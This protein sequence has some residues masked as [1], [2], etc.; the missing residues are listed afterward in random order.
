M[1]RRTGPEAEDRSQSAP[2]ATAVGLP[3]PGPCPPGPGDPASKRGTPAPQ[4]PRRTHISPLVLAAARTAP[5]GG[6]LLERRSGLGRRGT[7][8]LGAPGPGRIF[9][10]RPWRGEFS[11][12]SPFR[13]LFHGKVE[14]VGLAGAGATWAARRE[15]R[16]RLTRFSLATRDGTHDGEREARLSV[17][18]LPL[19][20]RVGSL[21]ATRRPVRRLR[22]GRRRGC[23]AVRV[24]RGGGGPDAPGAA[25]WTSPA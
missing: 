16:P 2:P 4:A 8:R 21:R 5:F 6:W 9:T 19:R 10:R 12:G 23:P 20:S 22:R 17:S 14:R 7:A 24:P 25:V 18:V 15:V 13:C 1:I 3:S 11:I